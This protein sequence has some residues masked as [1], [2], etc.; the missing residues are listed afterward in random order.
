M[1]IPT[2]GSL[3]LL[4]SDID[5]F[6]P[7]SGANDDYEKPCLLWRIHGQTPLLLFVGATKYVVNGV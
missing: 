4:R 1:T 5:F 7:T 3:F 2:D 6:V